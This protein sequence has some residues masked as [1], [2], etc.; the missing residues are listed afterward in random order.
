MG[1]SPSYIIC[2]ISRSWYLVFSLE[3]RCYDSNLTNTSLHLIPC[4]LPKTPIFLRIRSTPCVSGHCGK[5]GTCFQYV[6]GGLIF[7]TC[8][9]IAGWKGWGCTDGST[10]RPESELMLDVLLLTLSN[11]LFLPAVI[12]SAYRK[13]FTEAFVYFATMTSSAVRYFS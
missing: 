8:N 12:L 7:S 10:A 3:A 4:E 1:E 13:Y 6:S 11:L 2:S 5:Y 9:C